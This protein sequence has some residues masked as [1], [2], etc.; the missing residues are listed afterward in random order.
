MTDTAA[1]P[2][3]TAEYEFTRHLDEIRRFPMLEPRQGYM[4]AK[5]WREHGGRWAAHRL[6]TRHLHLVGKIAACYRGDNG[7][8][9]DWQ[10]WPVDGHDS[11]ESVLAESE[12][13]DN[14][15]AA[16]C[17]A[18]TVLNTVSGTSTAQ[19]GWPQS[20]SRSNGSPSDLR[21]RGGGC[22]RSRCAPSRRCATRFGNQWPTMDRRQ[23]W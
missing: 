23:R 16:L 17:G 18:L 5:R 15:R 3:I 19:V 10:E 9:G 2:M 7:D 4:P 8:S 21:F 20:R 13:I 22:A 6:V 14:R 12:A 11:R 1:S